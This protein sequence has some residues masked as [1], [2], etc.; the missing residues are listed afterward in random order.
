MSNQNILQ[1]LLAMIVFMLLLSLQFRPSIFNLTQ[2]DYL[3]SP[4]RV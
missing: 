2:A 4:K 3:G 1:E